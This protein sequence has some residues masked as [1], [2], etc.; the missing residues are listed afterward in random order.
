MFK[1]A[2]SFPI[3]VRDGDSVPGEVAVTLRP[4][5]GAADSLMF[6]H[7]VHSFLGFRH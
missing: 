7:C 6:V 4:T 5:G 1:S 2:Q 3:D